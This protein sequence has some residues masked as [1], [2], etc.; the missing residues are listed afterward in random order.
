MKK[1]VL[2][3]A[4]VGVAL[5]PCTGLFAGDRAAMVKAMVEKGVAMVEK[6]GKEA[7]FKAINDLKG[8]FVKGDLYLFAASLEGVSLAQGSPNN[9]PLLGKNIS[10]YPSVAKMIELAKTKGSGW[11]DY[12]WTKPGEDY[13]TPKRSFIQRVAGQD[14]FIGCGYYLK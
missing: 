6:E 14:F 5:G 11:V 4:M 13:P 9:K 12:S 1:I 2:M 8:P 7:A 10:K 3:L